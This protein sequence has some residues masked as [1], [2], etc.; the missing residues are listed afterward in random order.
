MRPVLFAALLACAALTAPAAAA[1]FEGVYAVR[2]KGIT[3]G[4]FTL[5]A[6]IADGRYE[7]SAERR[8][9]GL[10]RVAVGQ[11]Q[12][13]RYEA[14]GAFAATGP[15]PERYEHQGGRRNRL[16]QVA[17]DG[18][19]NRTTANPPMGMGDPPAS[20][21]QRRGAIDQVSALV[22]ILAAPAGRDPCARTIPVLMDGRARFDFVMSADGKQ[23]IS[24]G[25]WR[26]E[27]LRCRV[28][29]R[30]IAGFSDPQEAAVLSFL[31]APV[32]GGIFAPIRIQM[33]TDDVGVVTLD[34][35]SLK[36]SG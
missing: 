2:A 1:T 13:Y 3:A 23:K 15:Q 10:V 11:S 5:K 28:E 7:A 33:P 36:V 18:A 35:Q 21:A 22:A 20:E 8:S 14:E 19:E 9:T 6:A 25:P 24:S 16:V 27:A 34:V 31:L 12:D 32:E 26:G 30:P 4:D 17:F 29:F